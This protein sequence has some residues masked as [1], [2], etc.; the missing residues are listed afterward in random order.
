MTTSNKSTIPALQSTLAG[1]VIF[2]ITGLICL[3]YSYG[4][5]KAVYDVNSGVTYLG[6]H[7][8]VLTLDPISAQG[9]KAGVKMYIGN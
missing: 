7:F 5:C 9:Y 3:L 1:K 2:A 4:F 8:I 6:V